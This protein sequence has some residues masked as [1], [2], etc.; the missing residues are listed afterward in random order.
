MAIDRSETESV[1]EPEPLSSISDLRPNPSDRYL[2]EFQIFIRGHPKHHRGFGLRIDV[3]A[4]FEALDLGLQILHLG[5]SRCSSK[6]NTGVLE[7]LLEVAF[8]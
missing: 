7:S 5:A 3:L 1:L 4:L 8:L 2:V 6:R